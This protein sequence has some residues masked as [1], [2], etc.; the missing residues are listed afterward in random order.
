MTTLQIVAACLLPM[1]ILCGYGIACSAVRF[2]A[3]RRELRKRRFDLAGQSLH[4]AGY[5]K[6]GAQHH[7]A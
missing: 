4:N 6:S 3:E 1:F 2:L 7:G 5:T